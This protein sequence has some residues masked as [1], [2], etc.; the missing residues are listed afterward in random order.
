MQCKPFYLYERG[1]GCGIS[2]QSV[3]TNHGRICFGVLAEGKD[4]RSDGDNPIIRLLHALTS[5]FYEVGIPLFCRHQSKKKL[6]RSLERELIWLDHNLIMGCRLSVHVLIITENG[7]I[8]SSVGEGSIVKCADNGSFKEKSIY[9]QH[10]RRLYFLGDGEKIRINRM[11]G[12]NEKHSLW[13]LCSKD[14]ADSLTTKR[15]KSLMEKA[16][17]QTALEKGLKELKGRCIKTSERKQCECICIVV[18]K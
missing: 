13:L 16:D 2:L 10:K 18:K 3:L 12:T 8:A 15:L 6:L 14:F 4:M 5:W 17:T 9:P 1:G 7:Y 11:C